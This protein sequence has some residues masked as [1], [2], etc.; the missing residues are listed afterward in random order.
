MIVHRYLSRLIAR[1]TDE[2]TAA[3]HALSGW[4]DRRTE[5]RAR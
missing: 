5:A 3:V 1:F 2:R 4:K